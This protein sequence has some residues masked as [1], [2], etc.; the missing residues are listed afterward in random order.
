MDSELYALLVR[1]EYAYSVRDLNGGMREYS[2]VI[3]GY[4]RTRFL[5]NDNTKTACEIVGSDLR[6][7][8]FS[9][10][11]INW[12]SLNN[13][14]YEYEENA[15][16]LAAHYPVSIYPFDEGIALIKWV[17]HPDGMYFMD[18]DGYGM[19]DCDEES[20]YACIDTHGN[21]LVKFRPLDSAHTEKSILEEASRITRQ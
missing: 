9:L 3:D 4:W 1:N 21:V 19:E 15:R 17:L 16:Q 5:L 6:L 20:L 14:G 18:E 10:S 13:S 12:D 2:A 11:D 8:P 7:K